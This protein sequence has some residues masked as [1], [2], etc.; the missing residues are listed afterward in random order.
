[1]AGLRVCPRCGKREEDNN[2]LEGFCPACFP[3]MRELARGPKELELP[4]CPRCGR[5]FLLGSWVPLETRALSAWLLPKIR[6][7]YPILRS[8]AWL[9][10]TASTR[11][12]VAELELDVEGQLFKYP[13]RISAPVLKRLCEDDLRKAAGYFESIIQLRGDSERVSK[14]GDRVA[15]RVEALGSFVTKVEEVRGGVDLYLGSNI[16]AHKVI[17]ELD[18][19]Y[20]TSRALGGVRQGK[21]VYR[22]TYSVRL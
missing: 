16:A 6:S 4:E 9:E 21:Q 5:A 13:L 15:K 14:Y 11:V 19:P 18:K 1:M 20:E 17:S 7:K 8:K 10:G 12:A 2:F 3:Q 22:V